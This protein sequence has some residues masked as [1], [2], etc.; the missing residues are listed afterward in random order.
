MVR[1]DITGCP[2]ARFARPPL[3]VAQ[4][5]VTDDDRRAV[6]E[7]L[8]S[9]WLS[10]YG[11]AVGDFEAEF[12]SYCGSCFGIAT[13]SGTAALHLALA[14]LGLEP[15]DEVII[16]AFAIVV[17][18]HAVSWTGAQ[19]VLVDSDQG[20]WNLDPRA[21][22]AAVT[23]RTRAVL[24]VH[25]YGLPCDID[26]LRAAISGF[27][28][29]LVED[30][31]EAHGAEWHGAKA[32]ALGDL[33][34][35]SFYTNKVITTGEGG[36][37]VTADE[38]RSERIRA[39]RDLGRREGRR[40]VHD[41]A[42][43]NY[44]LS[45]LQA[46]LG[47]SQLRRIDTYLARRRRTSA[48]YRERL[49]KSRHIDMRADPPGVRG[50]EWMSAVLLEDE[51]L[52][53]RTAGHLAEAGIETRPFFHPLHLQPFY[54]GPGGFPVAEDLGR[55]GLLLPSG[56]DLTDDDVRYVADMLLAVVEGQ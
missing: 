30:A 14:S 4:P 9:T 19:P 17:V 18:H 43:F 32:G 5:V 46:A 36:M 54:E 34:C 27:D 35:F 49:G 15:G 52:R 47:R 1:A 24:A 51:A 53:D 50:S 37:V 3:K 45:A 40:Y 13:T 6:L 10:G 48:I 16:P 28:I 44:R 23:P 55:R 26:G 33:A 31:A 39:L 29:A 42:G 20:T 25:T 11:P 38:T 22:R 2:P 21:V 7:V 56:N 41:A 12:S 8:D